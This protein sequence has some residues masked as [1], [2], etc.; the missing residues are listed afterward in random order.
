[1]KLFLSTLN[2]MGVLGTFMIIGFILGKLG[3]L[4]KSSTKAIS[5]MENN[6]FLPALVMYTFIENFNM[7]TLSSSWKPLLLS[8]AIE[9]VIIPISIII[10]RR[11]S[12]SDFLR[13]MYTYGLCFSNF[14]FM[15]NAVV[16]ALF[17]EYYTAYIIFT[18]PLWVLIYVWGVPGLLIEREHAPK[19]KK[20][21][22]LSSLKALIN[23]MFIAMLI[24][25]II[26]IT[27]L[28]SKIA[29]DENGNGIFIMQVVKVCGG[30][31]S[32]LAM[33]MTGITF[34]FIDFKKV[35]KTISIYVVTLLRLIVYPLVIGGLF[36]LIDRLVV[37]ID[38]TFYVCLV[39]SVAMPLGLNTIVIP[40]AYGK[41]TSV[42]AGMA[43][44]SHVL[45]IVTIPLVMAILL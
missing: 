44:V 20:D 39:C 22:V 35:I 15:G 7:S 9:L 14:G 2:Q 31:M 19:D 42:P 38:Q 23:P 12:K 27:G 34:A 28:G 21:R 32:P 16:S 1:M 26:G 25:A 3:I 36:L 5:R 33:I 10:A 24:G 13:R 40:S 8:L 18:L 29:L 41:D 11:C 30:C 37:S 6:I 4:K 45:S 43:L 17:P